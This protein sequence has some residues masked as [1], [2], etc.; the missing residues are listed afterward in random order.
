MGRRG[1]H[2]FPPGSGRANVYAQTDTCNCAF[3]GIVIIKAPANI[4]I[5][6]NVFID[7]FLKNCRS[8]HRRTAAGSFNAFRSYCQRRVRLFDKRINIIIVPSKNQICIRAILL[9]LSNALLEFGNLIKY[10]NVIN[11]NLKGTHENHQTVRKKNR[12]CVVDVGQACAR[13]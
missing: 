13:P 8:E 11:L 9:W 6:I 1:N 7:Y 2:S 3:A 10:L 12:P 5:L 4:R